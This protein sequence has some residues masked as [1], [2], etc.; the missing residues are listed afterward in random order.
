ME[1]VFDPFFTTKKPGEGTGMG[2]AVVHGIVKN[3]KGAITVYSEIGK[4]TTFNVFLPRIQDE[5]KSETVS[6]ESVPTGR[7][8]I[9]VVDDEEPQLQSVTRMLEKLGY[10]VVGTSDSLEALNVFQADSGAFDLV[11]TDQTM[12]KMTG[13]K[14]AKSILGIR[15]DIPIILCTGF[16]E[17]IDADEA[18]ALGIQEFVMKPFTVK[19]MAEKIRKVLGK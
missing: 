7:E 12:P 14:L 2:L 11:I 6:L 16:S 1:R 8:R 13:E 9:L 3:H 5:T 19:E 10:N 4:G 15:P 17:V 18:K